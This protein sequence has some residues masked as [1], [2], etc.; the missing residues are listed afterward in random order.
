[1]EILMPIREPLI[2]RV[3]FLSIK[4]DKYVERVFFD[5]EVMPYMAEG[6]KDEELL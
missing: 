1:M 3:I 5:L 2:T 4:S 6:P